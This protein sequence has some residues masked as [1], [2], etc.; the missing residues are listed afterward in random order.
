[1]DVAEVRARYG[2]WVQLT[3]KVDW[4]ATLTF[5]AT[6]E[7]VGETKDGMPKGIPEGKVPCSK[8]ST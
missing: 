4:A 7:A 6:E 2:N 3:R 5:G 8:S 1:M